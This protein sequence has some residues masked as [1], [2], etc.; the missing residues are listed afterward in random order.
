[1]LRP[2]PHPFPT[3]R[4]TRCLEW[5]PL[6]EYNHS[7]RSKDGLTSWCKVCFTEWRREHNAKRKEAQSLQTWKDQMRLE[8]A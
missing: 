3:K 1:M 2:P 4:C 8:Y 6:E 5:W 7:A